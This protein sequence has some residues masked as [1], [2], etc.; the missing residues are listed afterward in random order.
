MQPNTFLVLFVLMWVAFSL[1]V[2][3][4]S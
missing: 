4:V 2:W 1:T 3:H